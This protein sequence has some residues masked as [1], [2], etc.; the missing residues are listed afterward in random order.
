MSC[1]RVLHRFPA[2]ALVLVGFWLYAS[3]GGASAQDGL[4]LERFVTV[5]R[6]GQHYQPATAEEL[7]RCEEL[8]AHT[9]RHPESSNLADDWQQLGF[10]L[11]PLVVHDRPHMWLLNESP[12]HKRGWGCYVICPERLPGMVLQAPHSFSDRYTGNVALRMFADGTF[13]AAAWNTVPRKNV[14]VAHTT[15]HPFAAFTRALIRVYPAAYVVQVHGFS[16]D[17]RRT[18]T[19]T[20]ADLIVSNG[21]YAPSLSIRRFAVMLQ[22]DF[23]FG[24]IQLFPTEVQELG[25]TSNIQGNI[26]RHAGSNRFM[27]LEMSQ[28]LRLRMVNDPQARRSLL[29]NLADCVD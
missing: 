16:Q 9:L 19:G 21:T 28:D 22:S 27:H 14:D 1:H 24:Q 12:Q 5:A 23:P 11:S 20:N 8:F 10:W 25:A 17:K 15:D 29:K 6:T 3:G 4:T 13:A 2:M 18:T 7:A 26:L